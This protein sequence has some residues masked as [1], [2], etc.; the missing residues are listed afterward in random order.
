MRGEQARKLMWARE[1]GKTRDEQLATAKTQQERLLIE[2]IYVMR[3]NS[4]QV[5]TAVRDK[6]IKEREIPAPAAQ[7]SPPAASPPATPD[8]ARPASTVIAGSVDPVCANRGEQAKKIAWAKESGRTRND[9]LAAA[10]PTT[11]RQL[12][13]EVYLSRG[14]SNEIA[15]AVID[16]C[17]KERERQVHMN[18]APA[19]AGYNAPSSMQ[20]SAN[21]TGQTTNL[22]PAAK[23][24]ADKRKET[25][26]D[27][28]ADYR[29]IQ[30]Q[31]RTGGSAARM[32]YLRE[33]MRKLDA[34][35]FSAGC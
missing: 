12:I 31:Q 27:Y 22:N 16:R 21:P 25:C 10:G 23:S 9:Q 6:C 3:G 29:R 14:N 24:E 18:A 20:P 13:E 8:L 32:E 7:A 28:D 17:A 34:A 11:D 30:D 33:E 19:A 5:A 4:L 15:A 35:R 2:E 26:R 1:T